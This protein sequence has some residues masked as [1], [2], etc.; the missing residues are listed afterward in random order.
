M[1]F[2]QSRKRQSTIFIYYIILFHKYTTTHNFTNLRVT[3]NNF[4]IALKQPLC[5]APFTT[6]QQTLIKP[7]LLHLNFTSLSSIPLGPASLL[8]HANV[9]LVLCLYIHKY[10]IFFQYQLIYH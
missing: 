6:I 10:L 8:Q 7:V 9:I 3:F 4:S 5:K 1:L 2:E